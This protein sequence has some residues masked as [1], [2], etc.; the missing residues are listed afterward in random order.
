MEYEVEQTC[1]QMFQN[2]QTRSLTET[3]G[4]SWNLGNGNK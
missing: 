2:K 1:K 3:E 4:S